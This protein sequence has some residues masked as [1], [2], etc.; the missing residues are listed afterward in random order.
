MSSNSI[1]LPM[2]IINHI[3]EFNP[4]HREKFINILQEIRDMQRCEVCDTAIYK[5]IYC[6]RRSY[7]V[8]CSIECIDTYENQ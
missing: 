1:L 7:M 6:R 5:Y 8:C 4:E 2:G 3:F